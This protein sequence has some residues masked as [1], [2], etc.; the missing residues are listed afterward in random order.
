[1]IG[2]KYHKLA[3]VPVVWAIVDGGGFLIAESQGG[4]AKNKGDRGR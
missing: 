4:Q 3:E 1:M 2:V